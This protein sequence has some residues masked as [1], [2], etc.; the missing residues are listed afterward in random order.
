MRFLKSRLEHYLHLHQ[1]KTFSMKDNFMKILIGYDG[2]EY[3]K[4]II[5]DLN[6]AGLP[7]NVEATLMTVA[8]VRDIPTS[9]LLAERISSQI[10]QLLDDSE[11][12]QKLNKHLEIAKADTLKAVSRIKDIFP[13]WQVST[14]AVYGKPAGELIKKADK[15]QPD[16]IVTGS[17]GH[18]AVGRFFLGSVSYQVLHEA[19]CSVRISRRKNEKVNTKN[20][21]LI[22]VDGSMNAEAVVQNVANRVW[23]K[24]TEFCLVAVD[25][26]FNRPEIGYLNW[27][28]QK[29]KPIN[30]EKSKKWIEEVINKPARILKSAGLEVSHKMI[31]GDAANM[32]LSEA[33]NWNTDSIF[34][35]ARGLSRIK[36][37][38]L[39]SV[40]S[41]VAARAVCSVEVIRK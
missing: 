26:P 30:N 17:H 5:D 19:R 32:I 27:D 23:E 37:F 14:K 25:D 24:E 3:G 21:I 31:W 28:H 7:K 12:H 11:V 35:G 29:D 22:A 1:S 4:I 9:P 8:D 41:R 15:M 20:R 18:S 16:L 40:S 34:L 13:D 39:G 38:L 10:E 2:S 6:R 33:E 36:R